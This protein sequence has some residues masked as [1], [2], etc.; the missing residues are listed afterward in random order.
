[1]DKVI[2]LYTMGF[3][4][5]SAE[6]FFTLLRQHGIRTVIDVRLSNRS[7]L[8]GFT[9]QEYLAYFLQKLLG[10]TYSHRMEFAPTKKLLDDF[11]KGVLSWEQYEYWYNSLLL[12]RQP[13]QRVF[14]KNLDHACLLCSEAEPVHCHRRLAAEFLK[15]IWPDITIQHI[16]GN[17]SKSS[18]KSHE[19]SLPIDTLRGLEPVTAVGVVPTLFV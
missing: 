9:K 14:E 12:Q 16:G 2:R 7:Q 4:C 1:M 17:F 18:Q 11:R 8:A 10:V 6:E 15:Y 13:H 19:S 3:A 5:K